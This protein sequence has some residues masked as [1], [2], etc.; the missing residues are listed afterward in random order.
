MKSTSIKF[1]HTNQINTI[2]L[3][4]SFPASGLESTYRNSLAD[5]ASMLRQNHGSKYMVFNVSERRYDI[6]KLNNQVKIIVILS[7]FVIVDNYVSLEGRFSS[8][9]FTSLQSISL[10]FFSFTISFRFIHFIS[11]HVI[12]FH[13]KSFRSTS[14]SFISFHFFHFMFPPFSFI[15]NNF[16]SCQIISFH[17]LSLPLKPSI[18]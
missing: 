2:I 8:S 15:S 4:M 16:I 3:A 1:K 6:S 18:F 7:L 9:F 10:H 12:L 13:L 5:V 17:F 11:N 14:F